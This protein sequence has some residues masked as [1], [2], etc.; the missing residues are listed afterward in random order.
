MIGLCGPGVAHGLDLC[1]PGL[2]YQGETTLNKGLIFTLILLILNF[3]LLYLEP[4]SVALDFCAKAYIGLPGKSNPTLP[5]KV[6]AL[7]GQYMK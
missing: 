7:E 6:N 1:C 5:E 2:K 4:D 3:I